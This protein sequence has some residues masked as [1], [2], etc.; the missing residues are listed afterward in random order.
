MRHY[1]I[2][3]ISHSDHKKILKLSNCFP[4]FQNFMI[5]QENLIEISRVGS[6]TLNQEGWNHCFFHI[7]FHKG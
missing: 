3:K 1:R 7:Y 2:G 5:N 6:N 4:C